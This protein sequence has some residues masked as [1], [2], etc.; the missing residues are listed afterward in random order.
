M[1][2]FIAV[3]I[4]LAVGFWG[5]VHN[6][7]VT[8]VGIVAFILGC[9]ISIIQIKAS[10]ANEYEELRHTV[11][12]TAN[13]TG[14]IVRG[15]SGKDYLL[16]CWHVCLGI[17]YKGNMHAN[18]PDGRAVDGPV[19]KESPTNDLCAVKIPAQPY[20]LH[21]APKLLKTEMLYSR[22]YPE[23]VLNETSGNW[24]GIESW[25]MVWDIDKVGQCFKGS[26]PL[27]GDN[28][29]LAA[30]KAVYR[31]NLITLYARPGSSGS[32][33]VDPSG[34][35]VGVISSWHP[36]GYAGMVSFEH[37]QEFMKGL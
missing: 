1:I 26:E 10:H 23:H 32:P 30:C 9:L 18:Y 29:I 19:V 31:D 14:S 4:V 36:S 34:G 37:L 12:H 33:V 6:W 25:D 8:K 20:A 35:L 24:V 7:S 5:A 28:G 22:G 13:G 15:K 2:Y 17:K 16:T 11:V 27:Y 3:G 21:L